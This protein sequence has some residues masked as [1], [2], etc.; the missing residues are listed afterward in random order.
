LVLRGAILVSKSAAT[1]R[2]QMSRITREVGG[3]VRRVF[4]DPA[5]LELWL[6]EVLTSEEA[7]RLSIFLSAGA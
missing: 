6:A 5:I 4:E 1:V 2:L 7:Q 3:P